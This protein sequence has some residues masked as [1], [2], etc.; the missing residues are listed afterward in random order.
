[1]PDVLQGIQNLLIYAGSFVVVLSVVVFV[2]EFG[3]FQV[4]RW[5]GVAI[6]TFSIGFGKTLLGWRDK[7][8]VQWKIGALPL[9]GYVK[10]ADDADAMSTAPREKIQDPA[11][12]AEARKK[13]LFHA[14]PLSTRSMVVAAGPLTN[15]V[16]AVFAFAVVALIMG[17]DVTPMDQIPAR[18]ATVT[19][20]SAADRAGL[21]PYDIVQVANGESIAN[22][23]E[24]QSLVLA[25]PDRPLVLQVQRGDQLI[26]LNATPTPSTGEAGAPPAGQGMLGVRPLILQSERVIERIGLLES[27]GVG[28]QSTWGILDQT[29]GYLGAVFSGRE[30]GN[31]IA[32]P[33]GIISVSGQVATSALTVDGG[34]WLDRLGVLALSLLSLAAVLS[35]A[36]GFVNLLPIPILDGG[37]LLFYGIEAVRGGRPLPPSAQEWAY[38]AGFAVMASLF[39]FA[40]WNDITRLFPGAQ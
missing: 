25:S 9:G 38:R 37:H 31:Q 17:R 6:D 36:V 1:M 29:L 7:H 11:E 14:Q 26:T 39:L 15:F 21:R 33:L 19:E 30:S 34:G 10:F 4:A 12:L 2:H 28:A 3:H 27:L 40:T 22:F 35:V 20:G 23:S 18:I 24:L 5:R 16:F 8:G 13:G 32:G